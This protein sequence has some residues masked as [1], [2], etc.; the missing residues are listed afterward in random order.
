[1]P[2]SILIHESL[3][4]EPGNYSVQAITLSEWGSKV[5]IN[6]TY[7]H[8]PAVLGLHI[9]FE[10][11]RSIEWFVQKDTVDI[12]HFQEAPLMTHDLGLGFY[13]RTARFATTLAEVLISYRKLKIEIVS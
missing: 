8:P 5:V 12:A 6:C 11:C 9:I 4:Y 7:R 10:D 1:M 2:S 3:G 13:E